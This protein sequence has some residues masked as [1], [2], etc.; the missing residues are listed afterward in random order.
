MSSRL[1]TFIVCGAALVP[2]VHADDCSNQF[3]RAVWHPD[4]GLISASLMHPLHPSQQA[5][6]KWLLFDSTGDVPVPLRANSI[7]FGDPD[8]PDVPPPDPSSSVSLR[9]LQPLLVD[10]TYYLRAQNVTTAGCNKP[11][12]EI[13]PIGVMTKRTKLST[14]STS[15]STSRDDSDFYFAPTI[16]GASGTTAAYTLDAKLQFRKE[17]RGVP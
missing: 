7:N 3:H 15:P 13:P 5:N 14:S 8:H 17:S 10:H 6:A 2:L 16:D 12:G 11:Q 9:P 4:Q 1:F